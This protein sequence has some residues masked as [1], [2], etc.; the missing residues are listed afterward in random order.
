VLLIA[1]SH[2]EH[3]YSKDLAADAKMATMDGAHGTSPDDRS[4]FKNILKSFSSFDWC[5]GDATDSMS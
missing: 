5:R 1:A 3:F 2:G 4:Q